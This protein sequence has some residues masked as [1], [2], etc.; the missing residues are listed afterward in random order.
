M[1]L[2]TYLTQSYGEDIYRTTTRLQELR[3]KSARAKNHI[4]FLERCLSHGVTPKSFRIKSPMNDTKAKRLVELYRRKLVILARNK[5]RQKYLQLLRNIKQLEQI[6]SD[7][8]RREDFEKVSN[9][10]EKS[11]ENTFIKTRDHLRKK[12]DNLRSGYQRYLNTKVNSEHSNVK[13]AVLNLT[14]KQLTAHQKEL[15]NLGPKFVPT[16]R[17]IPYMDIVSKTEVAALNLEKD[18]KFEEAEHLR[19]QVSNE[20][21]KSLKVR[22][23]NN[24]T[25]DQSK[26]LKELKQDE[27]I[28]VF[29]FDKGNGFAILNSDDA[30][31]KIEE[32]LGKAKVVDFDPTQKQANKIK[33]ILSKLRKEDKLTNKKFFELYPSDPIQPRMY[34]MLK[35]HKPGKN[36]PMRIVVSTI[37]TP[38]YAISKYLV[39]LI[40]PLLNE[41]PHRV[42]NSSEFAKEASEWDIGTNEVQTSYDVVNLYPSIPIDKALDVM[43]DLLAKNMDKIRKKSKLDLIDLRNLM[44]S[45]LKT[46]HF[47][48]NRT[49]YVIENAG[50]IGLSLMVVMAEG[51]LQ[52]LDKTEISQAMVERI[53]PITY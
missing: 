41:N 14:N 13:D 32:Q 48:W 39:D 44:D 4:V 45:C 10:V 5:E 40:Q 43:T 20:L 23:K 33:T 11:R 21:K 50:P 19:T 12:F 38:S 7:T 36:Y 30:I 18:K 42:I 51:Y 34:G 37:G 9:A 29:P 24:L 16:Q 28:K 8:I 27:T 17:K 35:A 31:K 2:K 1:S 47:I 53:Q 3:D 22:V 52:F 25:K 46:C 15:L 49:I 6:L 26:A